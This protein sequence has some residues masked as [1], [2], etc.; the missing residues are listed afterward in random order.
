MRLKKIL[1]LGEFLWLTLASPSLMLPRSWGW[2][3]PWTLNISLQR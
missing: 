1:F 3:R 2:I